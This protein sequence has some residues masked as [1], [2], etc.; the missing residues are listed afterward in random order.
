MAKSLTI[1]NVHTWAMAFVLS[2]TLGVAY[3]WYAFPIAEFGSLA[4]ALVLFVNL[5][6]TDFK[7]LK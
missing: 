4:L 2:L 5:V 7:D 3:A 1:N 6:K